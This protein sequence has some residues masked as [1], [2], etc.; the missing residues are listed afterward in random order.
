ML[1]TVAAVIFGAISENAERELRDALQF[2]MDLAK[3][4]SKFSASYKKLLTKYLFES[5][6]D[7]VE[8]SRPYK[9]FGHNK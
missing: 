5:L 9:Y 2:E 4:L 8:L 1:M 3:V 7:F 6:L